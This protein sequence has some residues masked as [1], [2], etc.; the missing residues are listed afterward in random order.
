MKEKRKLKNKK[1]KY[2]Y[3]GNMGFMVKNHWVYDKSYIILQI[4][5]LL[6]YNQINPLPVFSERG[7]LLC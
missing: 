4:S 6:R 2:S 1:K 3:M 7:N 5:D